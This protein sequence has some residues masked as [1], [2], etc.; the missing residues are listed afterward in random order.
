MI[1]REALNALNIKS[2]L[3]RSNDWQQS[4][5]LT[6][7]YCLISLNSIFY[8]SII[9]W[10][11]HIDIDVIPFTSSYNLHDG[12]YAQT[13]PTSGEY[14]SLFLHV[15]ASGHFIFSFIL[16]ATFFA[17]RLHFEPCKWLAPMMIH[18]NLIDA[19]ERKNYL[20]SRAYVTTPISTRKCSNI[21]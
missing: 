4:P 15:H 8:Y 1:E 11:S 19:F 21:H 20:K 10:H 17:R 14:W 13:W 7:K 5:I 9:T 3:L 2:K 16:I 6:L 12:F 18:T